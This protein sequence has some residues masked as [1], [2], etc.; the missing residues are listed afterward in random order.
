MLVV[1]DVQPGSGADGVLAPGDILVAIDG[2][3]IPE[4]FSLEDVLDDH[5]GQKIER[6]SAARPRNSC[7]IRSACRSL[8]AITP[9]E[10]IEFGEAVVHTLSYQQARHFN[11]PIKGCMSRTPAMFSAA[12]AFRAPP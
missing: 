11:V 6:G 8:S 1:D 9:D 5:V 2:K 10:Y 7:G 12:P 3:P 4:F